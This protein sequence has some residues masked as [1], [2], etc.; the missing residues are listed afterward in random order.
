MDKL[1][2]LVGASG[3]GKTTICRE[4]EGK[5][6]NVIKSYTTREPREENEWGHIFIEK[7]KIDSKALERALDANATPSYE[8][9]DII[10][11]FND[12]QREEIYFATERQYQGKGTS[13]YIVDPRGAE[14]V[15]ANVK[16]AEVITIF[17]MADE[18]ERKYRMWLDDRDTSIVTQRLKIDDEIFK[19]CKCDYVV[20]A[21]R[22]VEEVLKDIVG[23]IC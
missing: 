15:K 17:L 1:V 20:D 14:Q 11:L 16:D 23:I 21:N 10:A 6:L 19:T 3:S 18:E 9:S 4:L 12:Y 22:E 8:F 2:L 5:G 7:S 13:I